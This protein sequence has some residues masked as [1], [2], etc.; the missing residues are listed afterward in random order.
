MRSIYLPA[1]ERRVSLKAYIHAIRKAKANPDAEFKHG[2][3]SWWPT[4]GRDIIRQFM[5]GVLDRI[6]QAV[7]YVDRGAK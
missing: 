6:N 4:T 2:L 3:S 1:I 5:D 7:P